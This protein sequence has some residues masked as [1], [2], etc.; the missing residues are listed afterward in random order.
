[1]KI[2]VRPTRPEEAEMLC[3][4]QK[5]AFCSLYERY[6]DQNSPYLRGVDDIAKRLNNT[7]FRYFSIYGDDVLVGGIYYSCKKGNIFFDC[8]RQGEYYLNRVYIEP[9]HQCQ[10]IASTAILLCEKEFPDAVRF[11]V[12]FPEDLAK[13]RKCYEKAGFHDTGRKH[14]VEKGLVLALFEKEIK[15]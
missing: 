7:N 5:A 12:D 11:M 13:N 4:I 15:I 1:M 14:E 9:N 3:R 6:H 10:G 2:T 8:L